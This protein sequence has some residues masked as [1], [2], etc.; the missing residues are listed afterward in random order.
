MDTGGR[1][2]IVSQ[3][4]SN[5]PFVPS[6]FA[7]VD[8][9]TGALAAAGSQFLQGIWNRTGQA[10]GVIPSSQLPA[11]VATI[12]YVTGAIGAAVSGL[13]SETYVN[14]QIATATAP[15]VTAA[16]VT[17]QFAAPPAIGSTTPAAGAFTTLNASANDALLYT[18]ASAQ[19]IPT[20]VYTTVTGWTKVFDRVNSHF[21]ATTGVFTA[22]ATGYYQISGQIWFSASA[23]PSVGTGFNVLV[24]ANGVTVAEPTSVAQTTASASATIGIPGVVVSL[25]A[26]QTLIVQA[27][28][29]TGAAVALLAAPATGNF[30]SINRLA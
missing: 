16:E 8:P 17:A 4:L 27:R 10:T 15:L 18:N 25:A 2:V 24:V 26:G 9:K 22:P 19:S 21:S 20:G 5:L 12:T 11:G 14:T 3:S 7:F 23:V 28:Q 29:N 6:G 13:A 30:L 1:W